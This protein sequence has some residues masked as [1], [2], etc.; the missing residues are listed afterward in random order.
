MT[1]TQ[2]S[3]NKELFKKALTLIDESWSNEDIELLV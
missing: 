3:I 1:K 2:Q